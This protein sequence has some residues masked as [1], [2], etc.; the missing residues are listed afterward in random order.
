[1][2]ARGARRTPR[3]NATASGLGAAALIALACGTTL[4]NVGGNVMPSLLAGFG[5]RFALSDTS[6]GFVAAAQLLATAVVTLALSARASRP[7]RARLARWGL[8][9]ATIGFMVAWLSPT[10]GVLVGAN[11]VA[12]AGLGAVFAAGTAALSS[13]PDV[14]RATFR[15][16]LAATLA[17]A[18]LIMLVSLANGIGGGTAGFAVLAACCAAGLW[19]VAGLPERAAAQTATVGPRPPVLFLLAVLAFGVIEQGTWSYAAVF[20]M[21]HAGLSEGVASLALSVAALAALVGVP[22]GTFTARRFG[23]VAGIVAIGGFGFVAK[24]LVIIAPTGA[25]FAA[26]ASVWQIC[27][28]GLLVQILA[29]AAGTDRSGRLVA[30]T[31]GAVALGTGIGPAVIGTTL[32]LLGPAG[33]VAAVTLLGIAALVPQA[34]LAARIPRPGHV[35]DDARAPGVP[36]VE[37]AADGAVRAVRE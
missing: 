14:D 10:V 13:T 33:V 6:A 1:M 15:T 5:E 32:D 7:G 12:G 20:G 3:S 27:Y 9:A 26:A 23:R 22:L 18:A 8:G 4:G 16:V 29:L 36:A 28:L 24:A 37:G 11:V 17:T 25:V 31:A 35:P 21:R 30:A 2:A 19:G 34:R